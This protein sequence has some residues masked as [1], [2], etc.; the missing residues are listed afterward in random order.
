MENKIRSGQ[1]LT[2]FGIGQIVNF[3]QEFSIMVCG[4]DLWEQRLQ[5]RRINGGGD[6]VDESLL[7]VNEPRLSKLLGVEYFIKPFPFKSSGVNSHLKIPAVR[8]PG[9]HH[10]TNPSCGKMRHIALNTVDKIINCISC[11]SKMIPVRFV[12][13]CSKGHIQDVPFMEWVHNGIPE[14]GKAHELKYISGSGSGDLG[15]IYLKCS[16][17]QGKSLG[18]LMNIGKNGLDVYDSAL[19]R[20]GLNADETETFSK[21]NPNTNPNGCRC[22]GEK[23]WLGLEGVNNIQVCGEHLHVLIRGGSNVHYSDIMSAIHLPEALNSSLHYAQNIIEKVGFDSIKSYVVQNE[24]HMILK[25]VLDQYK[26][27]WE[28]RVLK[29]DLVNKIIDIVNKQ[30]NQ[31]SDS[32]SENYTEED[33]RYEEYQSML[34]GYNS[35]DS[36]FKAI[37]KR[38]DSYLESDF[39]KKFF[40]CV[41]LVEKIRETRVFTGFSRIQPA[42]AV[43]LLD[44]MKL[45]TNEEVIKWLP[46]YEVFGE[47]IFLKFNENEL[48]SWE[49]KYSRLFLRLLG[50]YGEVA[51]IRRNEIRNIT[52]GFLMIH[53]LAHLL[54][55]RLCF[56]CG[57]GSSSLRERIYFSNEKGMYGL[58]IYTSSGDSE[59]SLGGLVRQGKE[60]YL[61]KLIK[62]SIEDAKWCSADPVCSEIGQS[63]GQGPDNIN[64]SACHNCCIVPETSCEEFNMLL[65]RASII[66]TF[67]NPDIGFFSN[68]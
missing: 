50:Q 22:K 40:D 15:S 3:P 39:L 47:G 37:V 18:G 28:N 64:G 55:K 32:D 5:N 23:P 8:F 57:Y 41:V 36:D 29:E 46:A 25:I 31:V 2:P 42:N 24:D 54:I 34:G 19:A 43:S 65:D 67:D 60:E 51:S 11:E 9:W 10:C 59:G 21:E 61:G 4:L 20:I 38:F 62:E 58:L 14:G 1:L 17:G 49:M 63:C 33:L 16:C 52:P 68:L 27:I 45:L 53:T 56:D 35:E 66:G 7:R 48:I 44:R 13:A 30:T 26:K 12:A 6:S